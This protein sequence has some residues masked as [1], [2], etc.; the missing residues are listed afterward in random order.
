MTV[1]HELTFRLTFSLKEHGD[2]ADLSFD[3][4]F[5]R[6]FAKKRRTL[7]FPLA[8]SEWECG[9]LEEKFFELKILRLHLLNLVFLQNTG[10]GAS[11]FAVLRRG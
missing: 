1:Y 10:T 4:L 2:T 8:L 7:N 9:E 6:Y 3:A 11:V 5:N